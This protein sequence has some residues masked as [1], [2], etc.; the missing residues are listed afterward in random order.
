MAVPEATVNEYGRMVLCKD[1][2][3]ISRKVLAMQGEAKTVRMQRSPN[4][5]FDVGVSRRDGAHHR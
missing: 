5:Q 3:R 1:D 2:V 4:T